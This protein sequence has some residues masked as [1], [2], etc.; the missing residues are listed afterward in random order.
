LA[1]RDLS[2]RTVEIGGLRLVDR[3]REVRVSSERSVEPSE[4]RLGR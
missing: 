1:S 4:L 3:G 2:D